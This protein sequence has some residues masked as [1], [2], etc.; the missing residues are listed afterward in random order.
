MPS[1]T[2]TEKAQESQA[3][4]NAASDPKLGKITHQKTEELRQT[5]DIP[6]SVLR[7]VVRHANVPANHLADWICQ[8]LGTT[9]SDKSSGKSL[10]QIGLKKLTAAQQKIALDCYSNWNARY[11]LLYVHDEVDGRNQGWKCIART[12]GSLRQLF[13]EP[14]IPDAAF[15]AL[16]QLP[17]HNDY[18]VVLRNLGRP[19]SSD[20]IER[21]A[22]ICRWAYGSRLGMLNPNPQGVPLNSPILS[23]Q[24]LVNRPPRNREPQ[25]RMLFYWFSTPM[26]TQLYTEGR[27]LLPFYPTSSSRLYPEAAKIQAYDREALDRAF[28]AVCQKRKI[29]IV[30]ARNSI[31]TTSYDWAMFKQQDLTLGMELIMDIIHEIQTVERRGFGPV[32]YIWEAVRRHFEGRLARSLPLTKAQAEELLRLRDQ[33]V[34]VADIPPAEIERS[35][36]ELPRHR[37]KK[38]FWRLRKSEEDVSRAQLVEQ[39]LA[40][41]SQV[42][43]KEAEEE[44]DENEEDDEEDEDDVWE[45]EKMDLD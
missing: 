34:V 7:L 20:D 11:H 41:D 4:W 10:D 30:E 27:G 25:M 17:L 9:L 38:I 14:R 45:G 22:C 33:Y 32:Y 15:E 5:I 3:A 37:L 8:Q 40:V 16:M 44:D 1:K 2:Y 36:A 43:D 31:K 18:D 26:D 28:E 19:A 13:G 6:V 39:I 29:S 23:C 24:D 21:M 42:R 35:F 12:T